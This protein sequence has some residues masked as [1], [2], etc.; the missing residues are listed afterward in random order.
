MA[1]LN[2]ESFQSDSILV[3]VTSY[4][5]IIFAQVVTGLHP[6]ENYQTP[7]NRS[8]PALHTYFLARLIAEHY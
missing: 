5:S 2:S 7:A 8:L 3:L 1:N 6:L 4:H